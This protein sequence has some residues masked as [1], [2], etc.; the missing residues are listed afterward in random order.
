[1]C[2]VCDADLLADAMLH[3]AATPACANQAF[4]ISNGDTFRWREVGADRSAVHWHEASCSCRCVVW[5]EAACHGLPKHKLGA[6]LPPGL[7]PPHSLSCLQMWESIAGFFGLPGATPM[8]MPLAK[9]RLGGAPR[10]LEQRLP[11][12]CYTCNAAR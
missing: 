8:Q 10:S 11:Q 6:R 9:V 1:V 4:N 5:C 3:C 7:P 2:E 12:L